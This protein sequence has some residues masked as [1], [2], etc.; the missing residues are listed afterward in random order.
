MKFIPYE[1]TRKNPNIIVDG[2]ANEATILTLSHWRQSGTP[3]PLL[4]DTSAEIVF[5]YLNSPQYHVDASVV[6]NNHFDEDGLVGVFSLI[7]PEFA[8]RHREL[9]IAVANA[10]DFGVVRNRL[11]ARIVFTLSAFADPEHSP[12]PKYIF[13][14]RYPEL[15]ASL[16]EELL[17]RFPDIVERIDDYKPLWC[18]EE[19]FWNISETICDSH[20]VTIEE[21]PVLDLAIIRIPDGLSNS[22]MHR[23]TQSATA[24]CH[25]FAIHSRTKRSRLIYLQGNR[26]EFQYR[27]ESWV[28]MA[29]AR[30]LL[31]VDLA[32]LAEELNHG[33]AASGKW[34]FEGVDRITPRFYRE[35]SASM[36]DSADVISKIEEHLRTDPVAWNPY[37]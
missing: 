24:C 35:G 2:T 18:D 9:L 26:V 28:R 36:L 21:R 11:A 37:D 15:A 34:K 5:N 3:E 4:G 20:N 29:T 14:L 16:Y 25:H 8:F 30:P 32:S 7:D 17:R 23:F 1:G 19:N 6:S 27:Y 31:R 22:S 12:L 13:K 33:D 10:G